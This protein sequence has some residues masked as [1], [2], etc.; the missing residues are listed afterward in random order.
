MAVRVPS[1][2]GMRER[3]GYRQLGK[4]GG[5][6]MAPVVQGLLQINLPWDWRSPALP[7]L[8]DVHRWGN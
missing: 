2:K 8:E 5:F 4:D 3:G 7:Y 6:H 1:K